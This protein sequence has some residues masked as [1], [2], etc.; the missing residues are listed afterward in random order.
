[1]TERDKISLV[2]QTIKEDLRTADVVAIFNKWCEANRYSEYCYPMSEFDNHL[3]GY[4]P[5][6][7]LRMT[8]D[9]GFSIYNEYF[10]H[11][12]SDDIYSFDFYDDESSPIDID[13]LAK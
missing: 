12:D 2:K 4:S 3:S 8:A 6:K 9:I 1:M 11:T 5:S 7:I 13:E 10:W